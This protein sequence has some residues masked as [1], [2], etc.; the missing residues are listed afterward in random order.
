MR[1]YVRNFGH[2]QI[3]LEWDSWVSMELVSNGNT[4]NIKFYILIMQCQSLL[5]RNSIL[6][7]QHIYSEGKKCANWLTN[8]NH[9]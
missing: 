4:N 6:I 3:I 9:I 5:V 2:K 7:I 1:Q 8:Y